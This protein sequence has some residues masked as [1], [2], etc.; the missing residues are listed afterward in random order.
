MC[1]LRNHSE[2]IFHEIVATWP[3]CSFGS[4][5]FGFDNFFD[6]WDLISAGLLLQ[7]GCPGIGRLLWVFHI[8]GPLVEWRQMWVEI[9]WEGTDAVCEQLLQQL[10]KSTGC[11]LHPTCEDQLLQ[12]ASVGCWESLW[13]AVGCL[14]CNK[15]IGLCIQWVDT[16]DWKDLVKSW[17]MI[18]CHHHQRKWECLGELVSVD[19]KSNQHQEHCRKSCVAVRWV[20][21]AC[22][23]NYTMLPAFLAN[24]WV[25][26]VSCQDWVWKV[27]GCPQYGEMILSIL[28]SWRWW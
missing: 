6:V 18:L 23:C 14:K 24:V 3:V 28:C 26:Q 8:H 9:A 10:H 5:C 1:V 4:V 12:P 20:N 11:H 7:V 17:Y 15:K 27:L 16:A 21:L 13:R 2:D 22:H 19:E 25:Q